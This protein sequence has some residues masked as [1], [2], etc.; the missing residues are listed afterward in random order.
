MRCCSC[1]VRSA[2][3]WDVGGG[4]G[5]FARAGRSTT[6][7]N[8]KLH[9]C[10]KPQTPHWK[11]AQSTKKTRPW[12]QT[13]RRINLENCARSAPGLK[14][15]RTKTPP[16]IVPKLS[17]LHCESYLRCLTTVAHSGSGPPRGPLLP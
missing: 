16:R 10:K 7:Y 13:G 8:P 17:Q 5:Y 3:R 11:P 9:H 2:C 14:S 1:D 12:T 6:P 15:G 4:S